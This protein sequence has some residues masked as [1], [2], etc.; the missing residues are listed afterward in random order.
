MNLC[1]KY[2]NKIKEIIDQDRC[3]NQNQKGKKKVYW[4]RRLKLKVRIIYDVYND[5]I[6]NIN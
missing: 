2:S 3:L 1:N 5:D 6:K 4:Y